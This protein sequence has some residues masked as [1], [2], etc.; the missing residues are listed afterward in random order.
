MEYIEFESS[1]LP[2][3]ITAGYCQFEGD[4]KNN[5]VVINHN[6][7]NKVV[8]NHNKSRVTR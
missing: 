3:T 7:N 8:I 6:K 4:L 2:E 1:K 5:K